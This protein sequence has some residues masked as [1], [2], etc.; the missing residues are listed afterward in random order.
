[1]RL[2]L[3]EDD[4]D[5][6]LLLSLALG[7]RGH[8]TVVA[9]S[10]AEA[11]AV[12]REARFDAAIVDLGLPDGD[13]CSLASALGA[14]PALALTGAAAPGDVAR[15]RAAGFVDHLVKPVDVAR[16]AEVLA[17]LER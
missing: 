6:A 2:L 17:G 11:L 13:G 3:V 1:M 16:L 12:A 8:E 15:V 14:V 9:H 7:R 10:L 4:A 5:S